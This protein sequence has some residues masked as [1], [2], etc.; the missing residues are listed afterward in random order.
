[1]AKSKYEYVREFETEDK[2]LPNVFILVRID[3]KGFH[4]FS[5]EHDFAKPNDVRALN[6]MNHAAR[7][8]MN[9]L[10]DI[11]LGFGES[12]EY[13]FLFRKSTDLYQRREAKIVSTV[14]SLFT[15]AYVYYWRDYFPES[16]R[17]KYPPVFDGRAVLYPSEVEVRDYFAWRQA[18]THINNLFNT[19]FWALVEQGKMSPRA[20]E[21]KLSGTDSK[22]KN[23]MLFEEFDINYSKIP[24]IF[25]KGSILL[26][27]QIPKDMDK[28]AIIP[29]LPETLPGSMV[30]KATPFTATENSSSSMD[31]PSETTVSENAIVVSPSSPSSS[32]SS[33][34]QLSSEASA[35]SA[36]GTPSVESTQD[37]PQEQ[38]LDGV[39]PEEK[40]RPADDT[41]EL[42]ESKPV[43][44]RMKKGVV[45]DHI[46]IIGEKFWTGRGAYIIAPE[47]KK[48]M[49]TIL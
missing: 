28:D 38:E 22:Q 40:K 39:T 41:K 11:V 1:M 33:S 18:D 27:E 15:S 30:A 3:G 42:S 13:S 35:S 29:T 48:R 34:L 4:K 7:S 8:V 2:L 37:T 6:L 9:E 43:F 36:Q 25:R 23:S 45:I 32:S 10:D 12:D 16:S 31:T 21:I 19:S 14:V 24:A 46:D 17:P 44:K 49:R 47:K 5:A 26:R 20:A